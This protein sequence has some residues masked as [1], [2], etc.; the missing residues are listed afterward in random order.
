MKKTQAI[1]MF[2]ALGLFQSGTGLSQEILSSAPPKA[3]SPRTD[4]NAE[5]M[6]K[7]VGLSTA[8]HD[9]L[10]KINARYEKKRVE[11]RKQYQKD[12]SESVKKGIT[13]LRKAQEDDT[14]ALIGEE[15]WA[16]W[17]AHRKEQRDIAR[18]KP[19]EMSD[20]SK[21]EAPM[22]SKRKPEA[23]PEKTPPSPAKEGGN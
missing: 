20:K 19:M 10:I 12:R 15:K 18:Q 6:T 11:L 17:L 2:L 14:K 23:T 21:G 8:Q 1:L 7:A 9:S 16:Q 4:R 13:D 5:E 22:P 3:A